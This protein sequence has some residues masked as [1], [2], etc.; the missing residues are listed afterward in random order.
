MALYAATIVFAVAAL[1]TVLN[2]VRNGSWSE[3]VPLW[4]GLALL[5]AAET[6]GARDH[7]TREE[8]GAH[9]GAS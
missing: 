9:D 7:E 3:L 6:S 5:S 8:A 1:F 2:G 4:V